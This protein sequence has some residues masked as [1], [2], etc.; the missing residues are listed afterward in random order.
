MRFRTTFFFILLLFGEC[1]IECLIGGV[2]G[3]G[4]ALALDKKILK[5]RHSLMRFQTTY[6]LLSLLQGYILC[7]ILWPGGGEMVPGK[8]MKNEAVGNKMKKKEKGKRKKGKGKR[9]KGKGGA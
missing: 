4:C 6:F 7:K 3:K 9:R 8:K 2:Q 1:C 5:N